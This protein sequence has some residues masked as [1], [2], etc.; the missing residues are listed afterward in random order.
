[1]LHTMWPRWVLLR[2]RSMGA[3]RRLYHGDKVATVGSRP[4]SSSPAYQESYDRMK[5]LVT[6]LQEKAERISFAA[7]RR[8]VFPAP[9]SSRRLHSDCSG[10]GRDDAYSVRGALCLISQSGDA[11]KMEA[12]GPDAG[13]CNQGSSS[14]GSTDLCAASMGAV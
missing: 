1:M 3:L 10:R 2:G 13:S 7:G 5:A 8:S 11:G 9:P 14:S 12:P 4:D 6:E